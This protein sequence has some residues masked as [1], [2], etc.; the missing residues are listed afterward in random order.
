MPEDQKS[1]TL[2]VIASRPSVVA[3]VRRALGESKS[4]LFSDDTCTAVAQA[5]L[6]AANA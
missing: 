2:A 4:G 6:E 5:V 1:P 3:A